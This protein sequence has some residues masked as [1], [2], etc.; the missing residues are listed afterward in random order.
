MLFSRGLIKV[1]LATETFAVGVNM[2]ARSV[3]FNGIRKNDGRSWR[4][5]LPGEYTQMSGRAGRRGIDAHGVC[6]L[7]GEDFSAYDNASLRAVLVGDPPTLSSKF[8]VTYSMLLN[9]ARHEQAGGFSTLLAKSF[10]TH[11]A[12]VRSMELRRVS[13][14]LRAE[15]DVLPPP[16]D[17]PPAAPDAEGRPQPP[18]P[19]LSAY[20]DLIEER[21]GMCGALLLEAAARVAPSDPSSSVPTKK[22][23]AAKAA[24]RA[25]RLLLPAGRVLVVR[26]GAVSDASS[27]P[28]RPRLAVLLGTPQPQTA[29]ACMSSASDSATASV[30]L[31]LRCLVASQQSGAPPHALCI[32]P[33][34]PDLPTPSSSSSSAS[35]ATAGAAKATAATLARGA[36]GKLRWSVVTL[37]PLHVLHVCN[38][39]QSVGSGAMS[40]P[41]VDAALRGVAA[42]LA[43][44]Q[45]KHRFVALDSLDVAASLETET[46]VEATAE[47][48]AEAIVDAAAERQEESPT[49]T[50]RV[51]VASM[52]ISQLAARSASLDASIASHACAALPSLSSLLATEHRRRWLDA[53]IKEL[54]SAAAASWDMLT[55]VPQASRR[56][57][58]LR[59]L[60]YLQPA[61]ARL[62]GGKGGGAPGRSPAVTLSADSPDSPSSPSAPPLPSGLTLKGRVACELKT[63]LDELV[64]TEAVCTGLLH[65]LSPAEATGFLSLFVSKGKPP[66]KPPALPPA[67]KTARDEVVALAGRLARIQ[68]E[69]GV[70]EEEADD[71]VAGGS[72][73]GGDE[74]VGGTAKGGRV[75]EEHARSVLN[76][77]MLGA[78]YRWADGASF[79]QLAEHAHPSVAEGDMVRILSRVEE[80]AKEVRAAARL[81][82]DALLGRKLDA[83]LLAIRRDVVAAPSLYTDGHTLTAVASS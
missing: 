55:L 36:V 79:A 17:A 32:A 34:A 12:R 22:T 63:T 35:S 24:E 57:R 16:P 25:L 30:Q 80:L 4:N 53:S 27:T 7:A 23:K 6:I 44:L 31:P 38:S 70:L 66:Q 18:P 5:V 61:A 2:P 65:P 62:A 41:P 58:L 39:R 51:P 1:L 75:A 68:L 67:L 48:S 21:A 33:F 50:D 73:G 69:A 72:D 78:A 74:S 14:E 77:A 40:T 8:G 49:E 56:L 3:V 47:A 43:L 11:R 83:V 28:G 45:R 52:S 81:L 42:S 60:G 59:T 15:R 46:D 29:A 64:L 54:D 9:I 26:G 10:L 13:A 82:G 37:D 19:P 76:E 71:D 20:Y